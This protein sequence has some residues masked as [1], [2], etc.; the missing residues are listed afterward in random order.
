[1]R[2]RMR[3]EETG[4]IK[5]V[6]I[7]WSWTLFLFA[8]FFGVPLFLRRMNNWGQLML[9][10]SLIQI[11]MLF[12]ENDRAQSVSDAAALLMLAFSVFL[13]IRGNEFTAK[14]LLRKGWEFSDDD[15]VTRYAKS[16]W[17]LA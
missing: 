16:K 6:G 10:F 11:T 13:A 9:A 5:E 3:N 17:S 1:M 2:V 12:V 8:G 4:E 15:D 14:A 7:G